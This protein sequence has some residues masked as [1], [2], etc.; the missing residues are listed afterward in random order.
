V[1]RH[2][3]R[4]THGQGAVEYIL[5][6][7]LLVIVG[8]SI[9]VLAGPGIGNIYQQIAP[10]TAVAPATPD[11][12]T[13]APAVQP[14]HAVCG[15][16]TVAGDARIIVADDAP[17][18]LLGGPSDCSLVIASGAGPNDPL[19]LDPIAKPARLHCVAIGDMGLA[20]ELL[21]D[22]ARTFFPLNGES[23]P[24]RIETGGGEPALFVAAL[25][26]HHV[27]VE[28][29]SLLIRG[30]VVA[31]GGENRIDSPTLATLGE[32]GAATLHL[33][34]LPRQGGADA[35]LPD[36]I[37]DRSPLRELRAGFRLEVRSAGCE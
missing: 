1:S 13:P 17:L 31:V 2:F 14:S 34:L 8:V 15:H 25:Q 27:I 24:I 18:L 12:N 28:K 21:D 32:G 36:L 3:G 35:L 30:D 16:F 4:G 5:L 11:A 20:A 7:G 26:P 23:I 10:P 33:T 19:V 9:W 29:Q 37:E 6:I 22:T